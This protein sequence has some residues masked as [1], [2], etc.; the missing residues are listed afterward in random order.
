MPTSPSGFHSSLKPSLPQYQPYASNSRNFSSHHNYSLNFS[1]R[2]FFFFF[3]AENQTRWRKHK[4]DSQISQRHQKHEE[5][6][7]G[8]KENPNEK[9]DLTE[10]D[11]DSEDQTHHN[12]PNSQPHVETEVL[13]D[14]GVQ[15]S[16][17]PAV[18]KR[19]VNRPRSSVAAI[20]ALER[21]ID[22]SPETT[23]LKRYRLCPLI[24]QWEL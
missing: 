10:C 2:C 1:F 6:D 20:T 12:H 22:S 15:I 11:Y 5:E 13:S 9:E 8:D 24:S 18:I 19:S 14:H 4:R 21:A 23:R 7:D 3:F 17:F 16:Q